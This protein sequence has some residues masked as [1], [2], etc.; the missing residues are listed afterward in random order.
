MLNRIIEN[1][2]NKIHKYKHLRT[3]MDINKYVTIPKSWD[4]SDYSRSYINELNNI[5]ETI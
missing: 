5:Q 1:F 3:Q 2:S 4:V